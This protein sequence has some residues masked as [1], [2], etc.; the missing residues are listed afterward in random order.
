VQRRVAEQTSLD[1]NLWRPVLA[2]AIK[3]TDLEYLSVSDLYDLHEMLDIKEALEQ[4]AAD[5]AK[6]K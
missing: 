5:K 6:V 3:V 4:E 2:D 1:M